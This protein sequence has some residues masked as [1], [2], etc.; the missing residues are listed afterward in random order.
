[1][2]RDTVITWVQLGIISPLLKY[3]VQQDVR[4]GFKF[5][6]NSLFIQSIWSNIDKFKGALLLPYLQLIF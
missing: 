4:N 2:I 6:I 1:M 3:K 5:G